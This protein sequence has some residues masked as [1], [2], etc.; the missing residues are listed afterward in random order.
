MHVSACVGQLLPSGA[1]CLHQLVE[2]AE[3]DGGYLAAPMGTGIDAH[4]FDQRLKENIYLLYVDS[5]LAVV[6]SSGIH[7]QNSCPTIHLP[8]GLS[9][10][11]RVDKHNLVPEG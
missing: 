1:A 7:F 2:T 11:S 10:L 9:S 8:F 4:F 3:G 6:C 5:Y